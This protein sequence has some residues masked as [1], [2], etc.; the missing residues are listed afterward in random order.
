MT[1]RAA[2]IQAFLSEAGW[3]DARRAPLAG[4]ASNRRYERLS[5]A[6]GRAVLMD[7][8]PETGEDTRPFVAIANHLRAQGLSAPEIFHADTEAGLLLIEDLGDS[9]FSR[10]TARD[11]ETERPLY[12]AATDTLIALHRAPLPD[13]P[14]Y[15]PAT[16]TR[17]AGL[18]SDWY[19]RGATDVPDP[20]GKAR[21]AQ[22]LM[23]AFDALPAWDRVLV[24][25]DYHAENL[26]WLPDRRPDAARTGLLDFQD[27]AL[28]HP[29]YDLMSL[30]HDVRRGVSPDTRGA[31]IAHYAQVQGLDAA[32]FALACATLSAQR[33]LRILGVFARLS[34]HFAKPRYVDL[35]PVTWANLMVDLGH[36]ELRDLARAVRDTL[37][38]PSAPI[39]TRL[40]EKCGTVP[41]P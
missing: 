10:E 17:M 22:A 13:A 40:R 6:S 35:I 38:A 33:N 29:A 36:P 3:S 23:A 39:L 19:L 11:P 18:A 28:G 37:P 34:L 15:G 31:M 16:M 4:D 27:A 21:I 24:L 7:A 12:L 26:L 2:R 9:L 41:T 30:G 20:K 25:R 14:D 5:G 1:D 8:P 32:G